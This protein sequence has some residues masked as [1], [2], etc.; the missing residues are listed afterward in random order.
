MEAIL[1]AEGRR[2]NSHWLIVYLRGSTTALLFPPRKTWCL[3]HSRFTA[4]LE[5]LEE[6]GVS[7]ILIA[8]PRGD[9]ES[10]K[11]FLFLG[12]SR[13]SD[14]VVDDQFP[15]LCNGYVILVTNLS[16]LGCDAQ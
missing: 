15:R 9:S 8:V 3:S 5:W 16:E 6:V 11:S 1:G 4:C 12:F 10:F 14:E 7:Q 13:L 2:D